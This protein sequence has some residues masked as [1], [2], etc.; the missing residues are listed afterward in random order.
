VTILSVDDAED[1]RQ[2]KAA[3]R[4]HMR[5]LRN[6]IPAEERIR[7]AGDLETRLFELGQIEEAGTILL[8][9][10][11]GSEVPT[12][13][14]VQR[15]LDAGKRIL[16]PFL[17]GPTMEAAELRPGA[18]LA[19]TTYGPK[20]PSNRVPV[21][22]ATIAAVIAPGLAFDRQGYRL[23][24]GGGHYDRYL[25]RL[26]RGSPRVGISFHAQ[27]VT[28]VPHGPGDQAVDFVVTERETI[29]CRLHREGL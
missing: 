7:L 29:E 28:N 16:L 2:R 9:Y 6:S 21:D 25:A 10:S 15:L 23:G 26:R 12:A 18:S 17:A 19:T 24:Y 11:F 3:L 27:L 13:R 20:E 22:P 8:F 5:T 4:V 1:L 14:I